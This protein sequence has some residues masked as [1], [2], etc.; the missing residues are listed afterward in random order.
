LLTDYE[1]ANGAAWNSYTA[2][3]D[4]QNRLDY[5]STQNDNGSFSLTDYDQANGAAWSYVTWD[6]DP[7]GHLQHTFVQNDDG[8]TWFV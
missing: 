3:Y 1:Q 2:G 5:T 4:N 7:Q 8:S 6:Y